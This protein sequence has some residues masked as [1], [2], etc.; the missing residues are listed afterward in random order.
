[1]HKFN[2]FKEIFDNII[3]YHTATHF[4][5][6]F[7]AIQKNE[8]KWAKFENLRRYPTHPPTHLKCSANTF[9]APYQETWGKLLTCCIAFNWTFIY[10][11]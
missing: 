8:Q 7:L 5:I 2:F 10:W 4:K 1:M 3:M 9:T 11:L 6:E